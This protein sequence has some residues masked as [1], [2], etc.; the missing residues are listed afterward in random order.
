MG[1]AAVPLMVGGG[2]LSAYSQYS[3]GEIGKEESKV[4]AKQEELSATARE[5]DRKERLIQA[6]ASSSAS[7]GAR[8][9]AAYE[10][11]PLAILEADIDRE[12]EATTR[13]KFM[14]SLA[15]KTIRSRGK[16]Q[17]KQARLGAATSLLKGGAQAAYYS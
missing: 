16:I 7:A 17:Q 9:I 6:L 8:G 3:A 5:A 12:A 13:D 10:G 14:S 2:L 15:Q 11:S 1:A 4:A